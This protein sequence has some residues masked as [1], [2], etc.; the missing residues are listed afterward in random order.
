MRKRKEENKKEDEKRYVRFRIKIKE[1]TKDESVYS[2]LMATKNGDK[3]LTLIKGVAVEY[4]C[5]Y[6]CNTNTIKRY[7]REECPKFRIKYGTWKRYEGPDLLYEKYITEPA[8][9]F[10]LDKEVRLIVPQREKINVV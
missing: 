6:Y 4:I 1:L 9:N 5:E 3:Y 2:L 8:I 7:N 10:K